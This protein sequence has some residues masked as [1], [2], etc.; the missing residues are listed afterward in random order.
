MSMDG[1]MDGWMRTS[2]HGRT[3][4]KEYS[5]APSP[6]TEPWSNALGRVISMNKPNIQFNVCS[7]FTQSHKYTEGNVE[8]KATDNDGSA[9]S[10]PRIGF[11][12]Q[13]FASFLFSLK[14][15]HNTLVYI[16][17]T[18]WSEHLVSLSIRHSSLTMLSVEL[19]EK[20]RLQQFQNPA[21]FSSDH[22]FLTCVLKD[23]FCKKRSKETA[24]GDLPRMFC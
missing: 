19:K 17:K 20:S 18:N 16:N 21:K 12:H 11:L 7:L 23:F 15:V 2:V 8:W 24:L 6:S 3:L 1:W 14:A 5:L 4:C 9:S 13:H 22:L 10:Q